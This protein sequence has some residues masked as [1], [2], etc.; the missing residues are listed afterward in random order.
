MDLSE[1]N[2][3][4]VYAKPF[5]NKTLFFIK[6]KET[7]KCLGG[8][9]MEKGKELVF[10]EPSAI[11]K[12]KGNLGRK[13]NEIFD[14]IPEGKVLPMSVKEYGSAPN[15]RAQVKNYNTEKGKTVL[16]ATQ[17]TDEKENVTVWVTR[18]KVKGE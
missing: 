13:W 14:K 11:P 6:K 7:V 18:V 2:Y 10:L 4:F 15:I 9:N 5:Y 17:R 12:L 16:T 3:T 1:K 8:E